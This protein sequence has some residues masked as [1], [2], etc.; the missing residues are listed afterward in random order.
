MKFHN[1]NGPSINVNFFLNDGLLTRISLTNTAQQGTTWHVFSSSTSCDLE[2]AIC[3]WMEAY[4]LKNHVK[5][6]IPFFLDRISP[7]LHNVLQ[8]LCRIPFGQSMSY[9][10]LAKSINHPRAT[11]AVGNACGR[12]PLPL[13][14]PCHRILTACGNLGGFSGGLLVKEKLLLH[15]GISFAH[16]SQEPVQK[17]CS[18]SYAQKTSKF[19]F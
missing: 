11:R 19:G 14:I 4:C 2:K 10:Q 13:L 15:E 16:S 8:Q 9:Q 12:N 3:N 17:L 7:F 6:A 18:G 5:A 1:L